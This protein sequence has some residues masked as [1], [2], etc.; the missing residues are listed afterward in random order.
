MSNS[1]LQ[2]IH[3]YIRHC[4]SPGDRIHIRFRHLF[5]P[6]ILPT[7]LYPYKDCTDQLPQSRVEHITASLLDALRPLFRHI[8]DQSDTRR[9]SASKDPWIVL[10]VYYPFILSPA[11]KD[12]VQ[13]SPGGSNP[14]IRELSAGLR[15]LARVYVE[16]NKWRKERPGDERVTVLAYLV[17]SIGV[18][19]CGVTLRRL[20]MEAGGEFGMW[21]A[22]EFVV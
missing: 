6:L 20:L 19:N 11:L 17:W 1:Y 14:L 15:A 5:S 8:S 7:V 4:P 13:T 9:I 22:G 10:A 2:S 3:H 18:G 21:D 12:A 16:V